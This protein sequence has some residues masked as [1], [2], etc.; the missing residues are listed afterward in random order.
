MK[1]VKFLDHVVS[2]NGIFVDPSKVEAVLEWEIPKNVT[3]IY[4]FL[5]LAGYYHCFIHDF[6]RITTLLTRLTRKDVK[7]VWDDECEYVF[8]EL[9]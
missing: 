6:F 5:G 4:S 8:L 2:K 1:E 3:K 7:F 9:K